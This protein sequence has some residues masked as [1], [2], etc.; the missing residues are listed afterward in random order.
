MMA[1]NGCK[2]RK[3]MGI[4]AFGS[5]MVLAPV[6]F[7]TN[8]L[9]TDAT[10]NGKWSDEG[11]WRDNLKPVAGDV[12][13]TSNTVAGASIWVDEPVSVKSIRFEGSQGLTL[14]G[15]KITLTAGY[16]FNQTERGR[17]KY[18]NQADYHAATAGILAYVSGAT[19]SNAVEFAHASSPGIINA[20]RNLV[21][22]GPVMATSTGTF[23]LHNG[24]TD[25]TDGYAN[26]SPNI[27]FYGGFS[28]PNATVQS[29]QY[30]VYDVWFYGKVEMK[31]LLG[32]DWTNVRYVLATDDVTLTDGTLK[33]YYFCQMA[34]KCVGAFP[35]N[36]VF[37]PA[38]NSSTTMTDGFASGFN[39]CGCDQ[40]IDCVKGAAKFADTSYALGA[41]RST[42]ELAGG[43]SLPATLTLRGTQNAVATMAVGDAVSLVWDPVEDFTQTFSNR[44]NSTTG[45]ISVK[46]GTFQVRGAGTFANARSIAIAE[47]AVFD[48]DTTAAGAL[49]NLEDLDIAANGN[50]R[51]AETAAT[52]FSGGQCL[53]KV[54]TSGKITVEG[55]QTV[56]VAGVVYGGT[57]VADDTYD[58]TSGWID[59]DG[60]VKVDSSGVT[61]NR[62]AKF[63]DGDWNVADNWLGR[64][65]PTSADA[66][67]KI[68]AD[69]AEDVTVTVRAGDSLPKSIVVANGTACSALA[70]AGTVAHDGGSVTCGK[71]GVFKVIADGSYG[72]TGDGAFDIRAGGEFRVDG[73]VA[74]ITNGGTFAVGG[75]LTATGRV[76][77]TA[78]RL[79]YAPTVAAATLKVNEGGLVELTGGTLATLKYGSAFVNPL[80]LAGGAFRASGSS[81]Y[82]NTA[83][84]QSGN[85]NTFAM[86]FGEIVFAG[87][88][89]WKS[90]HHN[91]SNTKLSFLPGATNPGLSV[92]FEDRACLT[93]S[94]QSFY[95]GGNPAAPA[96]AEF[97]SS[98]RHGTPYL[99]NNSEGG[100][101]AAG[102]IGS[103]NAK[104]EMIVS[105]GNAGFGVCGTMI[106]GSLE[107][108]S[109]TGTEGIL[110]VK[111]GW[112]RSCGSRYFGWGKNRVLGLSVG[113]GAWT[114][115][116]SGRPYVGLVEVTDG[117][118]SNEMSYTVIGVGYARGTWLQ[119]GGAS[120]LSNDIATH[121][122]IGTAGG[123][124]RLEVSGGT[125]ESVGP[126][127]LGGTR[128]EMYENNS[129]G[130]GGPGDFVAAG[131]PADR[132]DAEGTLAVSGG[133]FKMLTA[134]KPCMLGMD[135]TGAIE[136]DGSQGEILLQDLVLSNTVVSA[137]QDAPGYSTSS[138]LSFK[139]DAD[140]VSPITVKGKVVNTPGTQVRVDVGDIAE[141]KGKV[142]LIDCNQWDGP[143]FENVE[144]VGTAA[145][146]VKFGMDDKGPYVKFA[147]GLVLILR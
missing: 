91:G 21:F 66:A 29:Q 31:A 17:T 50:L 110:R 90:V 78:G 60:F 99:G 122:A 100:I 71:G 108:G 38:W 35:A 124:G 45:S 41:I 67:V 98:A 112:F 74:A 111:G 23:S 133:S 123:I 64:K 57:R 22:F 113:Y 76:V 85:A 46:R 30:P 81:V 145:K 69:T 139:L 144:I 147:K 87:S 136:V 55:G 59:G 19:I 11:N 109:T 1:K 33:L 42:T 134:K 135:G 86:G 68:G 107:K 7:G 128:P 9:W 40:T 2:L 114:T 83:S 43:S 53:V 48:L 73:G 52:P 14:H 103:A 94:V 137:G 15:E 116:T 10:G 130:Q 63:A 16:V 54:A 138:R 146:D 32:S 75:S 125:V 12:V 88:S 126:V 120:R 79:A 5:V 51:V 72:H 13:Y 132:H 80:Q 49:A 84:Y 96:V 62:W 102:Y 105:G 82:D 3:T 56:T 58:K 39:L 70:I 117:V 92:R 77:V 34:A 89:V 4:V 97:T 101:A 24:L 119:K 61:V 143:A 93:N 95:L 118:V 25:D 27:Y 141:Y 44:V 6:A 129:D 28:A 37:A 140:G 20:R 47:N 142:R 131:W 106:G 127:Y 26:A 8:V 65:V 36:A 18:T 115:V 104:G 121:A